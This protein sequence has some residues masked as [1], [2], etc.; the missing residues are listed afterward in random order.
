MRIREAANLGFK[1]IIIP[2]RLSNKE[3][4]PAGIEVIEVRTI[5]EA[6]SSALAVDKKE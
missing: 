2:K 6:L 5:R 3:K 4:W 1:R